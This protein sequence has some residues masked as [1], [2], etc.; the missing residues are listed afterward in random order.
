MGSN[1]FSSIAS[2]A[3]VKVPKAKLAT[4]KKLFKKKGLSAKATIKKS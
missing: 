1:V 3:V 2:N 4:Y